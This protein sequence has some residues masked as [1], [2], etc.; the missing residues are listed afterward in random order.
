M[1][2]HAPAK[3]NLY[4]HVTGRRADG[5]HLLD[6]LAV[7]GPAADTLA[8]EPAEALTLTLDG[9]FGAT[10]AAEPDNLVLRAARALAPEG[11]AKGAALRLTK[12]LPVASGIGGG[13]A[14][15]AAALR[16][17][18]RLWR[19]GRDEA[20]LAALAAPLGADIPVCVASRPAVMQGVGE[21]I[22]PAPQLPRC[23]LLLVNPRLPL[24]TP[25]VFRA[26][27]GDFS[28]PAALPA[29]WPDAAAMA[30]DLGRLANDLEAPALSLCPAIAEVLAALRAQP[31][32]LLARMSGSGATCFGLFATPGEA[33]AAARSLPVAWWTAGGGL[34]GGGAASLHPVTAGV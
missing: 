18:N 27:Q 21:L 26:R 9:P 16:L 5:Y 32:C 15:A 30:A 12:R 14:D 19:S 33:E 10:L 6:S 8:A 11:T 4:L 28:P 3:V 20:A 24:A 25:A 17:L 34:Y 23:G 7:F 22:R 13:S 1:L 2:E 29:S 31:R